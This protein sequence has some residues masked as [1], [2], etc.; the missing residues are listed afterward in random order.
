MSQNSNGQPVI[1]RTAAQ[2]LANY[3]HARKAGGFIFVSGI[4]SRRFDNTW[5]G[6]VENADGTF[7][8]DIKAQTRAVLN[9]IKTILEH[10][11]AGLENLVD[12]TVFL[13][14]MRDYN[15]FNS[16]YNEFLDAET[17]PSRTTVAV[18]QLPNPRLLIEIKA[19]A[20]A[21]Q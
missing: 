17:G 4:S 12:L 1:V 15:D 9:N 18:K 8:L 6:V 16:V 20:L 11:G 13:V 19:V 5:E 3:P 2:S 10:A 14:D 21:P 7:V